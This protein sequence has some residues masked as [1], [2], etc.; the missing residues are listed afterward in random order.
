MA[1]PFGQV[2]YK[3]AAGSAPQL[4]EA[5]LRDFSGGLN[6][7]DSD[8]T[9]KS[10]YAKVLTNMHRDQDGGMSMRWGTRFF[11]DVSDVV[12]GSIVEQTYFNDRLIV[13]MDS[14]EIA[15]VDA[16]G[17]KTAIWNSTIASA[18]PGAPSGWSTGLV[19]IDFS[20]FKSDLNVTNGVD[21]PIFINKSFEVKYLQDLATGSNIY[22]PIGRFITTV[23]NYNVIA[24]VSA[25]PNELHISSKGAAGTF[26]GDPDPNDGTSI[27]IGAY[28]PAAGGDLRG[29]SS[30]RNFLLVHF[31]KQTV[32]V[33]LGIYD[34]DGNH[35]PKPVD[36]IPDF[37][38][39]SHRMGVALNQDFVFADENGVHTAKRNIFGGAL[40]ASSLSDKIVSA[41]AGE[42]PFTQ[43]DRYKSFSVYNKL[44][45]RVMFFLYVDGEW[46][47]W[48]LS[49]EGELKR[50]AWSQFTGWDFTCGCLSSRS[51][52]YL[53]KGTKIY[54]YGNSTFPDEAFTSDFIDDPA[55]TEPVAISFDWELP[56]SDISARM[57][58]KQ[59]KY[60]GIDTEGTATFSVA[61]FIDNFYKKHDGS[62]DPIVQLDYV[63]GDSPG[64][65]AG[66][67]PYG[68]GRR[69]KDERS[70]GFPLEFKKFKLRIF[71]TSKGRLKISTITIL[72]KA[73]GYHR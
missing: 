2:G 17:T 29:I 28:A 13:F 7:V 25:T 5:T 38:I 55:V 62:Y 63:A 21:K 32:P 34:T 4:A 35:T 18:L 26:A 66:D 24:G 73:S 42:T 11:V 40:E 69:A 6:L 59:I 58:K 47:I 20:E 57:R 19:S 39:I 65:G 12:A 30:F 53:A 3:S 33:E 31:A 37:G 68:G 60:L 16:D 52:I 22:V 43:A 51:R 36:V 1:T 9:I 10:N 61:A 44:E 27:N 67:Q 45:R 8:A 23:A 48:V 46:F 72:Y 70:W 64:Y 14:G 50:L 15:S 54:L 49:F 41:F 56:W 71:G